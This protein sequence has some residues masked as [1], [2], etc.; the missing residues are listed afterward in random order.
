MRPAIVAPSILT[1]DFANLR[2]ELLAVQKAGCRLLHLDVMD[3]AFVPN[4]SFGPMVIASIAKAVDLPL[5]IHLM[6]RNPEQFFPALAEIVGEREGSAITVHAEACPDLRF[7]LKK[8]HEMFPVARAGA[9]INPDTKVHVL[10]GSESLID[11]VTV[12][13]VYPGYGG[14]KLMEECLPKITELHELFD[15]AD[16]EVLVEI[17]GGVKMTNMELAK[18]ADILVMGSAIFAHSDPTSN[19]FNFREAQGRFNRIRNR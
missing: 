3:G 8:I 18:E 14:Q 12:M 13:T 10:E 1:I 11:Q 4:I 15:E 16:K 2:E 6:I 19:A 5:D 9:A 17:D 7:T